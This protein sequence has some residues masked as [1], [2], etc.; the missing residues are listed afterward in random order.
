MSL[1][2]S[3][4]ISKQNRPSAAVNNTEH[5]FAYF[6]QWT[7]SFCFYWNRD[8][9]KTSSVFKIYFSIIDVG[10]QSILH[11]SYHVKVIPRN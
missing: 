2:Q 9:R 11:Y 10:N 6:P 5:I 1:L 4:T 8:K 7:L 3:Y